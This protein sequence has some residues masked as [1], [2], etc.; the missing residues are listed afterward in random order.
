MWIV[1][2]SICA[3][4]C[5]M[6][7]FF[8]A[9]SIGYIIMADKIFANPKFHDEVKRKYDEGTLFKSLSVSFII[10]LVSFICSV[11]LFVKIATTLQ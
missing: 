5:A 6:I 4:I 2:L 1:F 10:F 3:A 9:A 7:A 11:L 8:F